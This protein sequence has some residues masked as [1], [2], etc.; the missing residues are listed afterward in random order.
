MSIPFTPLLKSLPASV[1]FTGPETLERQRGSQFKARL[2]AN[3]SA[4][5]ISSRAAL[6]I[7]EHIGT[8]GCSWYGDPENHDL[9]SLL[10]QKHGVDMDCLCVD[11]GIDALLGLTVRMTI[12][13]GT[14]VV[15]SLG[16]YPTFN[17]H[18]AGFGGVLHTVPYKNHHEDPDALID[19]AR[20]HNARL[21]YLSNP[22]NPMGTSLSADVTQSMI[23]RLPEGCILLLDEAYAEFMTDHELPELDMDNRQLIRFRTFSKAYGLAGM[24]IG[25]AMGNPELISGFNRIRNHFAVNRLAQIAAVASLEDTK[26]LPSVLQKVSAGRQ[27]IYDLADSLQLPYLRSS[28]NFVTVDMGSSQR[29]AEILAAL[30][31]QGIFLRKPMVPPQDRFIRFGVGTENEHAMLAQALGALLEN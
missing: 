17:Y 12:E 11:A 24:R 9:R 29:A 27:R 10:A 19:C 18:V 8:S 15:S 16:A 5:G 6:A 30:N 14:P 25:Y 1:P 2:G 23:E 21:V 20:Q 7:S 13:P 4:F 3:E 26:I 28:T 22:D 31:E